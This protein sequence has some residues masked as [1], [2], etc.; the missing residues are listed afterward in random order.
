M[1]S[2]GLKRSCVRRSIKCEGGRTKQSFK[3]QCDINKIVDKARVTGLVGHLN[4]KKPVYGDVSDIPDYQSALSIVIKADEAFSS[5][6]SKVRNR[7][8]N[9]PVEMI[10]FLS[11]KENFDEAV[12]L[13]LFVKKVVEPEKVQK[14]EVV[15]PEPKAKDGPEPAK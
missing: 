6:P 13:G 1:I 5:L 15:N 9:N 8:H 7:F 11:N 4:T 10:D 12:K 3:A 14:V 2:K